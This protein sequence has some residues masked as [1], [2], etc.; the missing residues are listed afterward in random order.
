M[1]RPNIGD[2]KRP[3]KR[4]RITF[5]PRGAGGVSFECCRA[6]RRENV[7]RIRMAKAD[8]RLNPSIG[9]RVRRLIALL[10]PDKPKQNEAGNLVS[11]VA[12]R[13]FRIRLVGA[14]LRL[15]EENPY[16]RLSV[17]TLLPAGPKFVV[18]TLKGVDPRR[19][20][21]I[22]RAD[23]NRCGAKTA[24]GW[25]IL[26]L[27]GEFDD[28]SQ[29][30][31]LHFHAVASGGMV[32]V[33]D[34]LRK[35]R[36]YQSKRLDLEKHRTATDKP[37]KISRKPITNLPTT[38]AYVLQSFW[39]ARSITEIGNGLLRKQRKKRRIPSPQHTEVLLWLDQWELKDMV[40]LMKI[41]VSKGRLKLSR[42]QKNVQFR[43]NG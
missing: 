17:V 23:L 16:R 30:Y 39:P 12:M 7:V 32:A 34:K 8:A 6:V 37:I 4:F 38:L 25:L 33:V 43:R 15:I 19:L 11:A 14:L 1:P 35:L 27:H 31:R 13:V 29:L 22:V 2:L 10:D 42:C 28:V 20:L 21:E 9:K 3:A 26:A 5:T 18:P 41:H 36:K 40:L 24:T